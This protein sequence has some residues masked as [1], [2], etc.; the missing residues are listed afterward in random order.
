M[1]NGAAPPVIRGTPCEAFNDP[2]STLCDRKQ[3]QLLVNHLQR[4]DLVGRMAGGIAHDFRN[5]LTVILGCAEL[6]LENTGPGDPARAELDAILDAARRASAL[7]AQLLGFTKPKEPAGAA[8]RVPAILTSMRDILAR[9]AGEDVTLHVDIASDP[10]AVPIE[11][12]Q[13]EQIVANLV[14][15]AREAMPNGG[16][17]YLTAA[18]VAAA[19]RDWCELTVRDTGCGMTAD[20]LQ[21]VKSYHFTT[22][23]HGSGLG[24]PTC[25]RI[26]SEAG[27]TLDIASEPGRGTCVTVRIPKTSAQAE[28]QGAPLAGD[29]ADPRGSETVLVVEDEYPLLALFGKTLRSLGYTPLLASSAAEAQAMFDKAN[30]AIDAVLC[31]VVLPDSNGPAL[32]AHLC[33]GASPPAIL[34]TSGH[35]SHALLESGR[36]PALHNFLQKPMTRR[37]L[38]H[39]L[40]EVLDQRRLAEAV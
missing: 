31:D 33:G 13:V 18:G 4:M 37:D 16:H 11:A 28:R 26:V 5:L 7:T 40:R 27:G 15:N 17:I 25:E 34:F 23:T 36:L 20:V 8:V 3:L 32:A 29:G 35:G 24:I 6:L 12:A 21:R 19:G 14:I 39:K 30:G 2:H 10:G 38:A 22:K 1:K 9:M